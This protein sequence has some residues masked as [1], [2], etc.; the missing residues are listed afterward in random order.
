MTP[1]RPPFGGPTFCL[2]SKLRSQFAINVKLT[3]FSSR[4]CSGGADF[5]TMDLL[6]SDNKLLSSGGF[7]AERDCVQFV[8][9][10]RFSTSDF[11]ALSA[12]TLREVPGQF[13]AYVNKRGIKP[14]GE[15]R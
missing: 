7:V 9:F 3:A 13:M 8:P 5:S 1:E 4:L 15:P 14:M 2:I 6:D 11:N 12:A 10:R